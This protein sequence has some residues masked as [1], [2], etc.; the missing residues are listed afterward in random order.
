MLTINPQMQEG[1][2]RD[3]IIHLRRER[4]LSPATVSTY[5]AAITHFYEMNDAT[6]KWKKLKKFKAKHYNVV[7]DKPYTREQ[8][9]ML[10]DAAPL[11]DKCIIL[12]MSSAG[13]LFILGD[14]WDLWRKHDIIYSTESDEILSLVN[15]FKD[16]YY[17]PG[18]HDHITL[19]T[20]RNHPDFNCYNINRYFRIK[21]GQK[22]FYLVHGHELEVISKLISMKLSEYDNISDQLCRMNDT[23]GNIASYLHETFHKVFTRGQPQ[24]T[25]FLQTAEQRKGMDAI[26]KLAKSKA[27]YPLLGMQ[28]DDILIFGH[29]HR[30][31]IDYENNVIN[32]GAWISDMLVPKWFEEEYGQD[33][34]CS[35]WYVEINSNG[36]YRLVPY[37]IHQKTK[38]EMRNSEFSKQR[39]QQQEELEPEQK[40]ND[41]DKDGK[42]ENIIGKVA[43]QLGDM[44]KQVKEAGNSAINKDK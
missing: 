22:N 1:L 14:F 7:E 43:S 25:D 30:P 31:Y 6:I 18:N 35:G 12:L 44:V 8:I 40:N 41:G 21:S 13:P 16:V 29:T 34:A 32:T 10:V 9:M 24:I 20:A 5:L 2:I 19:D 26:D 17:L 27:R 28:L 38:E 37:G 33:K 11:R 3:Y 15:Q 23:E 36:E 42:T 39:R 4:N